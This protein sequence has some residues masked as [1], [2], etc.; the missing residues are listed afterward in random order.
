MPLI[1]TVRGHQQ[2]QLL[3]HLQAKAGVA[4]LQHAEFCVPQQLGSQSFLTMIIAIDGNKLKVAND[5]DPNF[6]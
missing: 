1:D 4:G 2:Q 5:R 6:T 3:A